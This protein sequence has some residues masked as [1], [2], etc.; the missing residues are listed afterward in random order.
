MTRT[1]RGLAEPRREMTRPPTAEELFSAAG[2]LLVKHR[3]F[4]SP[5]LAAAVSPVLGLIAVNVPICSAA[6][7][8]TPDS[9]DRVHRSHPKW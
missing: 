8:A 6:G 1:R 2:Q 4:R 5:M 7:T 9:R 3:C